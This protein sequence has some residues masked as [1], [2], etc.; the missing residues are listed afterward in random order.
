[1]GDEKSTKTER[2]RKRSTH[3]KRRERKEVKKGG[4][5][6]SY[7]VGAGLR[8]ASMFWSEEGKMFE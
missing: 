4:G 7:V 1:M 5:K 3:T 8:Y 2:M 6:E